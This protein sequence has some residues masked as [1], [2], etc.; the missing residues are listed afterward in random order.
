MARLRLR[1]WLEA[2][3]LPRRIGRL[4]EFPDGIEYQ[5][6]FRL[7]SASSRRARSLWEASIPR[8]LTKALMMAMLA[9]TARG[10]RNTLESIETP[11]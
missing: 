7:S 1:L 9:C 10:L 6:E 8:S 5:S 3:Q 11:S 2:D 4:H